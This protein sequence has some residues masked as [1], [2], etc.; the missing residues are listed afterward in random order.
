MPYLK[1]EPYEGKMPPVPG[2]TR[3]KIVKGTKKG[4]IIF[5]CKKGCEVIP[6]ITEYEVIILN[7]YL[8]NTSGIVCDMHNH[9]MYPKHSPST[10]TKRLFARR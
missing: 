1:A 4:K 9:V 3:E 2:S 5:C 6:D 7:Y 8:G 10:M